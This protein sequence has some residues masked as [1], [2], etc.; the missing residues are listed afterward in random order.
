MSAPRDDARAVRDL[1]R[2]CDRAALAVTLADGAPYASLVLV[3]CDIAAR[4]ILL[5]S[6]LAEHTQAIGRDPIIS[7]LFDGTAGADDALS[8]ARA[9]VQGRAEKSD[10]ADLRARF[11]ARHPSAAVYV[12]FTDFAFYR[13]TPLRAHFIGGFGRISWVDGGALL[14]AEAADAQLAAAE[15]DVVEH[16]NDD[17]ADA[18][19]LYAAMADGPQPA[20]AAWVMT[21]IDPDGCDLRWG[22]RVLRIP[23]S[24][25]IESSEAARGELVRMVKAARSSPLSTGAES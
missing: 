17:H 8:G 1:V 6:K 25:R 7:L 11:L 24:R 9:S 22:G 21:G 20:D 2:A 10:D 18:V 23:F 4:P 3:A 16:M 15:A 13:V 19:A 5:I 12:D 14:D